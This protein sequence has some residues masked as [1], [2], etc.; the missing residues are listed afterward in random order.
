[1]LFRCGHESPRTKLLSFIRW[2]NNK[3]HL[4]V[5]D[6]WAGEIQERCSG[7]CCQAFAELVLQR[8]GSCFLYNTNGLFVAHIRSE[9][10]ALCCCRRA[11]SF[12]DL[13]K[14]QIFWPLTSKQL[15]SGFLG[16]CGIRRA[17]HAGKLWLKMEAERWSGPNIFTLV[18][19][20]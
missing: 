14:P 18:M 12:V 13:R 3:R 7:H 1:M 16:S 10:D 11:E 5:M 19:M 6:L 15:R 20:P 4:W 8:R 2:E 9:T 17:Q